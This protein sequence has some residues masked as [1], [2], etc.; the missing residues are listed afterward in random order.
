MTPLEAPGVF[1]SRNRY[2]W[3]PW[4]P[5]LPR[6]PEQLN[7]AFTTVLGLESNNTDFRVIFFQDFV[8]AIEGLVSFGIWNAGWRHYF[9]TA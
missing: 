3:L 8:F 7:S 4:L 2:P 6:F 5:W 9:V 1:L